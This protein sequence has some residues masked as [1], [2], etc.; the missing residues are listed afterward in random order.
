MSM[1]HGPDPADMERG[2]YLLLEPHKGLADCAL[3]VDEKDSAMA[4]RAGLILSVQGIV[5][6]L[7]A[8]RDFALFERQDEEYRSMVL[9]KGLSL[10]AAVSEDCPWIQKTEAIRFEV[11]DANSLAN[12]IK[13]EYFAE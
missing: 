6:R 1:C 4:Q 3:I 13:N 10:Y 11:Q 2:A 7:I 8:V 12:C 9:R 5:P